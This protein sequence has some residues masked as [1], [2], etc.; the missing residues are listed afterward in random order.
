MKQILILVLLASAISW[1]QGILSKTYLLKENSSED[2]IFDGFLYGNGIVDLLATDS[3]VWAATGYG[4]NKSADDGATWQNF[5]TVHYGGKG[6]VAAM[7]Y[8]DEQTFWISTAFDTVAQDQEMAAGGGLSYTRDGG[9]TWTHIKQPVDSRDETEYS[10]TTTNIS[11]ITYDIGFVD[12][13]V[14]ITSWAGGLRKSSDMGQ[15]WQ[16]VTVDGKP[17]RAANDNL[18]HLAFS[19]LYADG[20]LWVGTAGGIGKSSD[21]GQTFEIYKH[22]STQ[23]SISGNFV[24]ALAHQEYDGTIWAATIEASDTSEFRAVSFTTNGGQTWQ[25]TLDGVFAHNFAFDGQRVYAATDQGLFVTEDKGN[26][27]YKLPDIKDRQSG[28][29]IL[30]EVFY[31]VAVQKNP[32]VTRLWVGSADGLAYTEDNGNTWHVIRSYVRLSK[33]PQPAVYGYPS[34][35]SPSRHDYMRFEC[36]D[37]APSE[38]DIKIYDFSMEQVRVLP[39]TDYKPKWDGKN[40]A[41]ETVA[42]GVYHFRAEIKGQVTWGKIVVIN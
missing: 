37:A 19:V 21:G 33:R 5:R 9:A 12:S 24:V 35:F 2:Y 25:T 26:N 3:L 7:G 38:I 17:F 16:V 28:E 10:P 20:A 18:I 34:P 29:E 36:G 42:T 40:D 11:N 6:G 41:G 30:T 32:G 14:W 13:T 15:T 1:G 22:S 4:L 27:W 31:S 8:M 39:V 23:P